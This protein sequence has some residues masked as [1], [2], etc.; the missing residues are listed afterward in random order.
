MRLFWTVWYWLK[1]WFEKPDE[2]DQYWDV[3]GIEAGDVVRINGVEYE[4]CEVFG[5]TNGLLL[6]GPPDDE[7]EWPEDNVRYLEDYR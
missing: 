3:P 6:I 2:G 1:S 4:V 7:V 5:K